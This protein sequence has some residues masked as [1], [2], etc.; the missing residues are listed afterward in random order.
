[1]HERALQR[2]RAA[3]GRRHAARTT[4]SSRSTIES[5]SWATCRAR[6]AP[7][8]VDRL[9]ARL[10]AARRA[11]S[12]ATAAR[13]ALTLSAV[14][15]V[16]ALDR[17]QLAEPVEQLVEAARVDH[18]PDQRRRRRLV[19]GAQLGG[20]RRQ[21]V[22]VLRRAAA[23]AGCGRPS[24]WSSTAVQQ[25]LLDRDAALD[26]R[27]AA[28]S[29]EPIVPSKPSIRLVSPGSPSATAKSAA[30]RL[31]SGWSGRPR[32]PSTS[33]P[34]PAAASRKSEVM[35]RITGMRM[36]VVMAGRVRQSTCACRAP[37]GQPRT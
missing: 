17:G 1:M 19:V 10:H 5:F 13:A 3:P 32:W 9:P 7:R 29:S 4:A 24:S 31:G 8:R 2:A 15:R 28:P 27:P 37:R 14:D 33:T 11:V 12:A 18:D 36:I 30:G 35:R 34:K 16:A 22:G 23:R 21:V 6:R 26:R 20:Q 25:P